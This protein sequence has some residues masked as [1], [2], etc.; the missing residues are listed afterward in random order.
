MHAISPL[1]RQAV[2]S[3]HPT[4]PHV[5][6]SPTHSSPSNA[7]RNLSFSNQRRLITNNYSP[8]LFNVSIPFVRIYK[9]NLSLLFVIFFPPPASIRLTRVL[10]PCIH[11]VP[12]SGTCRS[13]PLFHSTV[14][15]YPSGCLSLPLSTTP[16][17]G[18]SLS[19]PYRS[20]SV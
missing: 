5:H 4:L 17:L 7:R 10:P 16:P 20:V 11:L 12:T 8:S 13:T 9:T 2:P 18:R 3:I 1:S 14:D 6:S 19:I 15:N